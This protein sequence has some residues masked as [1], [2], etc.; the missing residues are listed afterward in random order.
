MPLTGRSHRR[1][2]LAVGDHRVSIDITKT[3]TQAVALP[4]RAEINAETW[5]NVGYRLLGAHLIPASLAPNMNS[6][7]IY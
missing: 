5:S 4:D 6:A 2:T 3:G 1:A 7:Q